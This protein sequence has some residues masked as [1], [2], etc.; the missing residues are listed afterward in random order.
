MRFFY[1]K[2]GSKVADWG[3]PFTIPKYT[4]EEF[5]KMKAEYIAKNGYTITFPG[6]YDIIKIPI[7]NPLTEQEEYDWSRGFF[8][9]F[10]EQRYYEIQQYKK[11]RKDKFLAMLGSPT[12]EVFR[13]AGMLMTAIDNAQDC[14][15][16]IGTLGILGMRFSP[17]Q[18]ASVLALPTGTVL[19]AAN[20][21]NV[22][23]SLGRKGMPGKEAKRAWQKKTG[24]DP[25]TKKGRIKY[26]K[27]LMKTFPVKA[28]IIQGL[29][30]TEEIFGVGLSLGPIVGLFEDAIAGP[31]RTLSGDKVSVKW[32][33]PTYDEFC[34]A[35]QYYG[36]ATFAYFH[37]GVQTSDEE[38]I[39]MIT[40]H[41]LAQ[42]ALFSGTIDVPGWENYN[43]L[44]DIELKAPRPTNILTLEVI[45]EAGADVDDLC[46]WPH[47]S[48][49]W[50][51]VIDL[52]KEYEKPCQ[53]YF[54][55]YLGMHDTDWIGY[56]FKT[57]AGDATY[58]TYAA[59]EGEDQVEEDW[60]PT[61]RTGS[62]LLEYRMYIDMDQ[63]SNKI[64]LMEN[65]ME[66]WETNNVNPTLKMIT[67]YCNDNAIKII[68]F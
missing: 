49:E 39:T 15:F 10:S 26:A 23:Q 30:T 61:S 59:A 38:V 43:N 33:I 13:N 65:E 16:T 68:N 66:K 63:P 5:R 12:P 2:G 47:N 19:T 35:A 29:Q 46:G 36:R 28:A 55:E 6:L 31:I 50:A 14:L 42:V 22:I 45:K 53:D 20:A 9:E 8:G 62:I 51:P 3:A 4:S 7:E 40:A 57:L 56:I 64:S 34:K 11:K 48:K 54:Y 32:P 17:P 44:Y 60:T 41:W 18:V 24:I 58:Y 37:P 1:A 52:E 21:L 67:T 27:H 25:W